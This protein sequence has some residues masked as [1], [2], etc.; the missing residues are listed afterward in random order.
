MAG[1]RAR[2]KRERTVRR[3]KVAEMYYR[4][5]LRQQ[6]I[7][8]EIG[9]NQST[10]SRDIK[11]LDEQWRQRIAD[12]VDTVRARELGDLDEMERDCAFQLQMTKSARWMAERLKVKERRARLLGLDAPTR[13][14]MTNV[15]LTQLTVEQLERIEK[16]EDPAHVLATTSGR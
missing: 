11:A 2:E 8:D 6:E 7:A 3:Q 9:C 10:I 12:E 4:L 1:K 14:S 13:G 16:G 15:D 5:R